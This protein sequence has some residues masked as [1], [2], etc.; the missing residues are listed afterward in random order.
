MLLHNFHSYPELLCLGAH[1]FILSYNINPKKISP[2]VS[3]PKVLNIFTQPTIK[4]YYAEVIENQNLHSETINN[5]LSQFILNSI[6]VFL[7]LLIL[8]YTNLSLKKLPILGILLY[9]V[10]LIL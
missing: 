7:F 4:T 10:I 2:S 9:Y 5:I 8:K 1:H 3:L 6:L